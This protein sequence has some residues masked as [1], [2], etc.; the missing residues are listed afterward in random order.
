MWLVLTAL[1][2]CLAGCA[3]H[4]SAQS[5]LNESRVS[6]ASFEGR[7]TCDGRFVSSGKEVHSTLA[8]A[9][10][11]PSGALIVHHDD[12][13]PMT[14]HSLEVW[15][16]D[17]TGPGLHASIIDKYSGMRVFESPGVGL[18]GLIWTRYD[19][20]VPKERFAYVLNSEP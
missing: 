10:D 1:A 7:W 20:G 16:R 13:A 18:D 12:V 5:V 8:M 3:S 11:A 2:L 4:V 15:S 6:F 19:D 14:Y 9:E 17:A